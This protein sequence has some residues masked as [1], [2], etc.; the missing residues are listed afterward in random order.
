MSSRVKVL[1]TD[2]F[3]IALT[4]ELSGTEEFYMWVLDT[5]NIGFGFIMGFIDDLS[6]NGK[7][8]PL[9]GFF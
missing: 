6:P 7:V 5:F 3:L 4:A 8:L 2:M 1:L 9:K